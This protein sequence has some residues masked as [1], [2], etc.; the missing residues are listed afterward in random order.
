MKH[1]KLFG[2]TI[3]VSCDYCSNA[4]KTDSGIT[5]CKAKREIKNEKCFRFKYNPLMRIP[6]VT[7]ALPKYNPEDFKL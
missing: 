1:Y 5:Y 3:K 6:K 7:P 2:N 4:T